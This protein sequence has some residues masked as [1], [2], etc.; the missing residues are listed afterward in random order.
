MSAVITLLLM[1]RSKIFL[2]LLLY[3]VP[4]IVNI[5]GKNQL[6]DR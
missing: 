5:F 4:K 2:I 3:E 1:L 6:T